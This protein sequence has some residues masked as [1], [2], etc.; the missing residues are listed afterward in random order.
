MSRRPNIL[1]ITTD[2][3][4]ASIPHPAGF[5]LPSRERLAAAGT[6]F[7]NYYAASTMC[8]SSRSV[9][10]TGQHLPH[11]AI[12]DN[13]NMPYI[14]PLDPA[15]GT[16]GT[17]LRSAGYYTTYQ[18]KWHL[19]NAYVDPANP[20]S[21][22]D[23]LEPY[24]FSE[25]NDWGD[26]DGGA[27]AGL[28]VD[29]VI[30][31][32]AAGWLRN[33]APLVSAQQP[34]FM[35]VN[36]V[37]PHDI[38]SFDYGSRSKVQLPPGLSHAVATRPPAPIPVYSSQW[39][40]SLPASAHDDLSGAAPAVRE[41]AE[42]MN[43]SFGEVVGEDHW[44]AGMNFYLNCL[45]DVDRS[46]GLV[47][48]ALEAS[49]EA[50]HTVVVFTADHGDMVGSHGLRQKGNLV[51]D[52]NFHVPFI[53]RHPDV[54]GGGVSAAMASAV[55]LAPTL[56]AFA[57]VDAD[58]VANEHSSL[59]GHSLVPALE[60]HDVRDGVLTAVESITTLDAGYWRHFGDADVMEQ[61]QSGR[62]RPDLHK[63]GFLR[64]Y[65]DSRY[66]FG[67]YFAP[68]EPNR[69]TDLDG[70]F[71]GNDVV[72]YDRVA[73]PHE[74]VNIADQPEHRSLVAGYSSKLEALIT[75]EVGE[76]LHAW[77]TE[78]PALMGPPSGQ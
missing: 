16:I 7:S 15:L 28:Q 65:T 61:L 77:V 37:N 67:R 30:A 59:K 38:M 2:E 17:M 51:Y 56:L 31:G 50:D 76:D 71:A 10:Y 29:P 6:T 11:T 4:R 21:T 34:W 42:V 53:V 22:K 25:W 73:D 3:E 46:I 66:S 55:D 13:D 47:L 40:V 64:G 14:R 48:D 78:R 45:R 9:I 32:Q 36:F 70:L 41:Y 39:D 75:A 26:I 60:G 43:V 5:E 1:L 68:L 8:S 27:W 24:G 20:V 19:S 54:Q 44:L 58:R 35:A 18:G 63:R 57:G 69:P 33:R 72:L 23:V 62:L 74:L 12:Y 49:G 52:E